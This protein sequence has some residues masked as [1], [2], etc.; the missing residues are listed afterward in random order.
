[1][2]TRDRECSD[3]RVSIRGA[4]SCNECLHYLTYAAA[5]HWHSVDDQTSRITPIAATPLLRARANF[6]RK[7]LARLRPHLQVHLARPIISPA[8]RSIGDLP[9]LKHT[10]C[11]RYHCG[12]LLPTLSRPT[13][14][15]RAYLLSSCRVHVYHWL[16]HTSETHAVSGDSFRVSQAIGNSNSVRARSRCSQTAESTASSCPTTRVTP[17]NSAQ[18]NNHRKGQQSSDLPRRCKEY[19]QPRNLQH[20]TA[21]HTPAFACLKQLACTSDEVPARKMR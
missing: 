7:L 1:V 6:F 3:H 12:R 4:S 17:S 18:K 14:A 8:P 20:E 15:R 9:G 10:A 19:T 5:L 21:S 11:S 13:M 16:S 2:S